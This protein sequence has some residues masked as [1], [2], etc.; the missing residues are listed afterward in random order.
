MSV[1]DT[2]EKYWR[3][4]E[5]CLVELHGLSREEAAA[6]W[7]DYRRRLARYRD[8]AV[9][10]LAYH[11]EPLYVANDLAGRDLDD[12]AV[13]AAYRAIQERIWPQQRAPSAPAQRSEA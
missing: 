7:R 10:D 3:V 4:V 9:A 12:R 8:P 5:E 6:R 1:A 2:D 13:D 11:D